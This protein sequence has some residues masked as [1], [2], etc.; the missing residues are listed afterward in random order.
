MNTHE[1]SDVDVQITPEEMSDNVI[2]LS[3]L[4]LHCDDSI[5]ICESHSEVVHVTPTK[6]NDIPYSSSE[7]QITPEKMASS[8]TTNM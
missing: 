5:N 2:T 4:D 8:T 7:V 1:L 3:Q 6:N